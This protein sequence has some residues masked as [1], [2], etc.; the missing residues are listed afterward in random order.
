[1]LALLLLVE[2]ARRRDWIRFLLPLSGIC[3]ALLIWDSARPETSILLQ[4]AANNAPAQLWAAPTTW[5]ERLAEW[6]NMATWLLG[7]PLIIAI[8]LAVA[9]F[10]IFRRAGSAESI[11]ARDRFLIAAIIAYSFIHIIFSFN[12][13]DRYLLL[14]LPLM[15][16]LAARWIAALCRCYSRLRLQFIIVRNAADQRLLGTE[17]RF[18]DRRRPPRTR[19]HRQAGRSSQQQAGSDRNL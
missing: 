7:P 5:L 16:L 14:I 2:G 1:M 6:L 19:W 10:A 12:L 18:A 17:Q 13:Y 9:A 15:I 8:L 3:L 4:A 11:S